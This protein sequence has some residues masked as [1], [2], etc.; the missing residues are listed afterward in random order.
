MRQDSISL[1]MYEFAIQ[2][3]DN[4]KK[5]FEFDKVPRHNKE[6]EHLDLLNILKT[7]VEHLKDSGKGLKDESKR[8]D[9]DNGLFTEGESC[10]PAEGERG[11]FTE[12]ESPLELILVDVEFELSDDE[13]VDEVELGETYD[14]EFLSFCEVHPDT[15]TTKI[16]IPTID[17]KTLLLF[18]IILL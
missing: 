14:E 6:T 9:D 10:W 16:N 5:D 17:N 11:R 12:G 13:F 2:K 18:K 3:D 1:A 8:V 15:A 7:V 4:K